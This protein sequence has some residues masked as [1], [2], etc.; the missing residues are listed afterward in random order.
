MSSL[1][2][3]LFLELRKISTDNTYENQTMYQLYQ[4]QL[5]LSIIQD[6]KKL[7]VNI[8]S[9]RHL[10]QTDAKMYVKIKLTHSNNKRTIHR[11]QTIQDD[12]PAW[13]YS[14]NMKLKTTYSTLLL[15]VWSQHSE[16]LGCMTFD[17]HQ[18]NSCTSVAEG[19]HFLL[20]KSLGTTH[21][22]KV[23]EHHPSFHQHTD[24]TSD[25]TIRASYSNYHTV[26]LQSS[27][28]EYGM[29]LS[30]EHPVRICKVIGSSVA[31][32]AGILPEDSILRINDL[33]VSSLDISSVVQ[34]IQ[35][36]DCSLKLT[37][38]R[39]PLLD[40]LQLQQSPRKP[41]KSTVSTIRPVNR[42]NVKD[43]DDFDVYSSHADL[44]MYN[45][46]RH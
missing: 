39:Q 40:V 8:E 12:Q 23:T 35:Q 20:H 37:I 10:T 24:D 3:G 46:C 2:N 42:C 22:L 28:R 15:S 16:C 43:L 18:Q 4:G 31:A 1:S 32:K 17:I 9:G 25:T 45:H 33:D 34:L 7:S 36:S 14:C 13:N 29:K 6:E 21:H 5:N 38:A 11:T 44:L 27:S 30:D 19:W 41:I 26:H